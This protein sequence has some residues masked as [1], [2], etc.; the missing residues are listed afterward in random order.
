M[1]KVEKVE[2][3]QE[4]SPQISH[5]V[6]P[7]VS[8]MSH[9]SPH[10]VSQMS[11]RLWFKKKQQQKKDADITATMPHQG[12]SKSKSSSK[13]QNSKSNQIRPVSLLA[14]ISDFDREAAKI[15]QQRQKDEEARKR[16]N[17]EA[18]YCIPADTNLVQNTTAL[19][20]NTKNNPEND[21]NAQEALDEIMANVE[22]KMECLDAIGKHNQR[23]E[24]RMNNSSSNHV[25]EVQRESIPSIDMRVFCK[26]SKNILAI[27]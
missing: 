1:N 23:W 3:Q 8:Q 13:I 14:S 15:V 19:V 22:Q 20:T 9:V 24:K 2:S 12:L 18:F 7:P 25:V 21:D 10:Q 5:V 17:D 6:P 26:Y 4:V 11:P 16:V 27:S